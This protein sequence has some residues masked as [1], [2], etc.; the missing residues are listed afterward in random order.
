M[1]GAAAMLKPH[2][3]IRRFDVFAEY[4]RQQ[5]IEEGMPPDEAKGYGLW[6]AKVVAARRFGHVGRLPLPAAGHG[7][8]PSTA[9]V[10]ASPER[11]SWRA[12]GG[13][14]QT[15]ARFDREIVQRMGRVFYQRVFVPAI[16]RAIRQGASYQA[17]HDTIRRAWEP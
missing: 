16:R 17:I 12:L 5:A 7:R 8:R 4:T 3:M 11:R 9:E 2:A 13:E 15:D 10:E 6:L 1:K 14:P